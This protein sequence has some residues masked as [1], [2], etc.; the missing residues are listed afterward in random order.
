[1][2]DAEATTRQE[3]YDRGRTVLE[4]IDG[5]SGT[6]VVDGLAEVSPE[7]GHQVVAWGSVKS[8]PDQGWPHATDS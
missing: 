4:Q 2:N 1:M 6:A 7:L 8:T 3:R 5:A